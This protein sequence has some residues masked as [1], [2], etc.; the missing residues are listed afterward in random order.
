[1]SIQEELERIGEETASILV[2]AHDKAH[3]TTQ[4]AQE[5]AERCISEAAASA[6]AITEEAQAKLRELDGET[7]VVRRRRER[8]IADA[9]NVAASLVS[10]ADEAERRFP[11]DEPAALSSPSDSG[12]SPG[13]A[14]SEEEQVAGSEEEQVAEGM[15]TAFRPQ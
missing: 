4:M 9:R 12:S 5:Q 10:L 14:G 7:D 2:V 15:T 11:D 1:M 8:L 13:P 6:A 3:E